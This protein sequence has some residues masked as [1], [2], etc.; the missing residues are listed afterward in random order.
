MPI[1][2]SPHIGFT[3]LSLPV[4]YHRTPII[5]PMTDR[6]TKETASERE[7]IVDATVYVLIAQGAR[8]IRRAPRAARRN[9]LRQTTRQAAET[10][11]TLRDRNH[12]FCPKMTCVSRGSA[13]HLFGIL[14]LASDGRLVA[15]EETDRPSGI[16]Q[17]AVKLEVAGA[18]PGV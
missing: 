14:M 12:T 7:T 6:L 17:R 8:S 15:T 10:L 4:T 18:G 1:R 2:R 5:P 16:P 11:S 13:I 9:H 3:P